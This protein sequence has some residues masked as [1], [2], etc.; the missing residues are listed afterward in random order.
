MGGTYI[1][2]V[3]AKCLQKISQS[4]C[5]V[6]APDEYS[7]SQ[8][9]PYAVVGTRCCNSPTAI[10]ISKGYTVEDLLKEEMDKHNADIYKEIDSM[11]IEEYNLL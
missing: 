8:F 3:C 7:R 5:Y 6:E 1:M 2:I 11:T 4:D 10:K 9:E